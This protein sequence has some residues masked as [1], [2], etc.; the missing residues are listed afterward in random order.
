MDH[1][2]KE[3]GQHST[4]TPLARARLLPHAE[5]LLRDGDAAA[6]LAALQRGRALGLPPERPYF[7]RLIARALL[8]LD[9]HEEAYATLYAAL[10]HP[11]TA[12]DETLHAHLL[13]VLGAVHHATGQLHAAIDAFSQALH[14]A[15]R[16]RPSDPALRARLL[17][18]MGVAAI[19]SGQAEAATIYYERAVEAARQANDLRRLGLA[20]MGL[21]VARQEAR[22]YTMALSHA[23]QAMTLFEQVGE[24]R[25]ASQALT[26][27]ALAHGARNQWDA[28]VPHLR[29]VLEQARADGDSATEA[30]VLEMLAR[31]RAFAGDHAGAA[32]LAAQARVTA[33][34][35]DDM[36]EASGAA[37]TEAAALTALGSIAEAED[38]YRMAVDYFRSIG[39]ARDLMAA[40]HAYA[41]ALRSWGRV[42]D[43][44]EVLDQAYAETVNLP[45]G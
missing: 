22:D 24:R 42:D 13:N 31:A 21:G 38:R 16:L 14:Y 32:Q 18:N 36:L 2:S 10:D 34:Q 17:I 29:R 11:V 3:P 26:N 25:L 5:S 1:D 39:A 44:L 43:A 20:H 8:D 45:Q 35:V 6:A 41:R 9:R 7:D 4:D 28:A 15:D 23:G 12:G 40:S 19:K 33:Q 30:H 37:L 27:L